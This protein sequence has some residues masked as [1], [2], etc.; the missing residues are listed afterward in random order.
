V[1]A[2]R[3]VLVEDH[4]LVRAGLCTS[5]LE[6]GIDVVGDASDAFEGFE[7]IVRLE[8]D[9]AV[10]DLGLPGKDGITLTREIKATEN[11]PRVLILTMADADQEVLAALGA[12]A[13]GYCVKASN[14]QTIVDAVRVIA[15]GGAYFDPHVAHVVLGRFSGAHPQQWPPLKPRQMQILRLIAEGVPN[16]A[17]AARLHLGLGTVKGYVADILVELAAADRTQAAVIAFRR[18]ILS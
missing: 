11:A 4:E 6:A 8:P 9:I 12:G 13:D 14:V 16:P 3:V 17:I 18:G 7:T 10:V 1:S 15:S 2:T 5:L